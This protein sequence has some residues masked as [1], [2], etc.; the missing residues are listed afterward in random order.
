M[1]YLKKLLTYALQHKIRSGLIILLI[2]FGGYYFYSNNTA[3]ATTVK[4]TT[5]T[6]QLGVLSNTING[7]GQVA[8]LSQVDLK[9]Q[10]S[11]AITMVSV[12]P[13]DKVKKGKVMVSLNQGNA[14]AAVLQSQAS[15]QSTQASYNKLVATASEAENQGSKTTQYDLEKAKVDAVNAIADATDSVETAHRNLQLATGGDT[16]EIVIN[17]YQDA[18]IY[19]ISLS[20]K[21]DDTLTKADNILGIDN[22]MA[23]DTYETYLSILDSSKLNIAKSNYLWARETRTKLNADLV[24]ININSNH[25]LVDT[26]MVKAESA[27]AKMVQLMTSMTGVTESTPPVGTLTQATLD[28]MKSAMIAGRSTI[29][30]EYTSFLTKKRSLT[31]AKNSYSTYQTAYDKTV[32]DLEAVKVTVAQN[33]SAKELALEQSKEDI[34]TAR[35]QLSSSQAQLN[36]AYNDYKNNQVVAPF[37]GVVAAVTAKVGDQGS[38]TAAAVTLIT[39]QKI[40]TITL[41]EVDTAK[42]KVGQKTMLVFDAIDNLNITGEVAEIDTIGTVSQGVVSYN[43]KIIFDVQDER[44]KPGMSVSATV[45]LNSK[46]NVLLVLT[47]AIKSNSSGYYVEQLGTDGKTVTPKNVEIGLAN[48]T[49]TEI[50]SGLAGGDEIITQ[51]I[52]SS[53]ATKTA[54][55]PAIGGGFGGGAGGGGGA[56]SGQNII[57]ALR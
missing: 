25:V 31:D 43:V 19:L 30:S 38:A 24:N 29:N 21:L 47:S 8:A 33:I 4:Y 55:T 56:G 9:P 46:S 35:A 40:A 50:I 12:K 54:T 13:G 41:N 39:E 53:S 22:T 6:V 3:S 23:N 14:S 16:S 11:G 27:I 44:V 36:L 42:I 26:A 51:K 10:S 15:F 49:M 1:T 34:K 7:T 18:V 17:A 37:D 28:A 57:R 2:I 52:T 20:A 45:V 32:R 5:G 48:D